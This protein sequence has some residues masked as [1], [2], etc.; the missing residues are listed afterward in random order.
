MDTMNP[1]LEH[2]DWALTFRDMHAGD[3]TQTTVLFVD[4][5][6]NI[7]KSKIVE[8]SDECA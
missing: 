6:S 1:S 4:W 8:N 2:S 7:A 5:N 3:T